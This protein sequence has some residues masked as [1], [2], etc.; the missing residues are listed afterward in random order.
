MLAQKDK[1]IER[2]ETIVELL[3]NKSENK[4]EKQA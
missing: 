2:L 1:N 4:G 3:K